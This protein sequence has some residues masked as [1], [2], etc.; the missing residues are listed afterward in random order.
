[1]VTQTVLQRLQWTKRLNQD[2]A[3]SLYSKYFGLQ[4]KN[5]R[6]LWNKAGK[7]FLSDFPVIL[8][9]RLLMPVTSVAFIV[10]EMMI[11]VMKWG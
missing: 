5:Y 6:E 9:L 8:I 10:R 4:Y 7:G 1:M 3:E 11:S 2:K